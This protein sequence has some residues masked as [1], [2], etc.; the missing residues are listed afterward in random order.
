M[1]QKIKT[2]AQILSKYSGVL[3]GEVLKERVLDDTEL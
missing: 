1:E 3:E 2:S